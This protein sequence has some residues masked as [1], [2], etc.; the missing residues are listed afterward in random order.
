MIDYL[1]DTFFQS[2][3]NESYKLH[4]ER[5]DLRK[6]PILRKVKTAKKCICNYWCFNHG[7]KF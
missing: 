2:D 6:E 4:Y 5:I 1:H 3:I 7:F